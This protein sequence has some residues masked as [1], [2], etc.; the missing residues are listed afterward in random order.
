MPYVLWGM[1]RRDSTIIHIMI[2]T[3]SVV[4]SVTRNMNTPSEN[5]LSRLLRATLTRKDLNLV[6]QEIFDTGLKEI[7]DISAFP[8]CRPW[9]VL[10]TEILSRSPSYAPQ[11]FQHMLKAARSAIDPTFEYKGTE[12]S[13]I[14]WKAKSPWQ[15]FNW[16]M[17]FDLTEAYVFNRAFSAP[18]IDTG[19]AILEQILEAARQLTPQEYHALLSEVEEFEEDHSDNLS[20]AQ[21]NYIR[22]AREF[23][24]MGE[25][26]LSKEQESEWLGRL[27]TLWWKMSKE[28]IDTLNKMPPSKY[29]SLVGI[30]LRHL[31]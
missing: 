13:S 31:E 4:L 17:Q 22:A 19:I 25:N 2:A 1:L 29:N 9:P 6:L 16:E 18:T 3:P 15:R 14:K 7:P 28:E 8:E 20:E 5:T 10:A 23:Y 26:E 30:R 12:Q 11:L 24:S 27:D 21:M